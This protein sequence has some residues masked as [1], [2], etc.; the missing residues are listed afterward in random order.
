MS[1]HLLEV[2]DLSIRFRTK[3]GTVDAVSKV[4]WH[5]DRGETLVILG[6]SGSGKSVTASA[7]MG[8]IDIPPAEILSGSIAFGD[9][10]L[11]AVPNDVRREINGRRIA[12]IFQ[13][14]L[15]ALNPVY[16]VGRQIAESMTAH[17]V[18]TTIARERALALLARVGIP[19][20]ERRFHDYPHQ[21][22]GGQ[23]QRVMIAAAIAMR[24][25]V[26]IADEPT[27][28]LDVTVQAG[29]LKLL[30]QLQAET[31][32]AI[33]LITH[34]IGVA[35]DIGERVVV[36]QNGAVVE[37]GPIE[38]V[39]AAPKH[40]YTKRLLDSV[41]GRH[42]YAAKREYKSEP[43]LEI[44]DLSK[45]YGLTKGILRVDTGQKLRA[46]DN[47]TLSLSKGE[48]LGIV[49]ES[50]SGKSTLVNT[51]LGLTT[52]TSGDVLYRGRSIMDGDRRWMREVR[53]HIQVV[54]QDPTASLNPRMSIRRIISEPWVVHQGVLPRPQWRGR[55]EQLLEQVG[56]QPEHADRYPHQFSGGQ[57]QRIAIAR[58]LALEPEIIVCDEAVSALDVSIQ[59]QII[60]LLKELRHRL[61]LSYLFV[62]HDLPVIRDFADRT[63]VMK[64]GRIVEEGPTADL[65]DNPQH[66]YTRQLLASR[67][68]E[69]KLRGQAKET[70]E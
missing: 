63:I 65:F 10:D 33:L 62:A 9:Q 11:L 28:A 31:G 32:M 45:F 24:P 69:E 44:R 17:G 50:G 14:P 29:I 54:F 12:M 23:R 42:G 25:D 48:V 53:R 6:E 30:K 56:L 68:D 18:P 37:Q 13:D 15:A 27:S 39:L 46:L 66:D 40:P 20:S 59:S 57:R 7:V 19:N 64:D 4:S 55:V 49:G 26:L 51:L 38:T 67:P 5:V 3:L 52:A 2:R 8:L 34:D 16:P 21:F 61:G 41:P 60:D 35:A 36:M 70:V 58:A 22:S 47:V 43:I 1:D